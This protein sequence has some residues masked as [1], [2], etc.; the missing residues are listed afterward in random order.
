[1]NQLKKSLGELENEIINEN[2]LTNYTDT[3]INVTTEPDE[4]GVKVKLVYVVQ[5]KIGTKE[6]IQN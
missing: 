5:E 2:N 1:M 4:N 3:E 6:K